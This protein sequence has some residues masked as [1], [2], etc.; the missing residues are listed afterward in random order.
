[1]KLIISLITFIVSLSAY[2]EPFASLETTH[3]EGIRPAGYELNN[4]TSANLGWRFKAKRVSHELELS[5]PVHTNGSVNGNNANTDITTAIYRATHNRSG[6]FAQVGYAKLDKFDTDFDITGR[7]DD[8]GLQ[9]GAGYSKLITR[10]DAVSINTTTTKLT[11]VYRRAIG[12]K[13][14]HYFE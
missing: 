2:A 3:T 14:T 9:F 13:L 8:K 1:M 6:L 10:N 7:A 11:R 4:Q 12:I 5:I